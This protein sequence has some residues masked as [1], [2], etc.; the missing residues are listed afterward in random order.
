MGVA[1]SDPSGS[2]T[3]SPPGSITPTSGTFGCLSMPV[4]TNLTGSLKTLGG[5]APDSPAEGDYLKVSVNS[6]TAAPSVTAPANLAAVIDTMAF[7][8]DGL[9]DGFASLS[10]VLDV[11]LAAST[12]GGQLPLVGEDLAEAGQRPLRPPD[13]PRQ[14]RGRCLNV[15]FDADPT[16]AGGSL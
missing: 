9:D 12:I 6:L 13:L 2:F 16:V 14:P 5:S 1:S 3:C 7:S 15:P 8:F 11:A 10:Q 4:L